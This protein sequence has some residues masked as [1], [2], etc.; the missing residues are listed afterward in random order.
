M[1]SWGHQAEREATADAVVEVAVVPARTIVQA[2]PSRVATTERSGLL[3]RLVAIGFWGAGLS[4]IV[5]AA[6]S[7]GFLA[8]A[9]FP[10]VGFG[11]VVFCMVALADDR[12]VE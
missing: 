9:L 12:T 8:L 7:G 6:S 5:G 10:I 1:A 4:L 2:S 11:Y 3:S